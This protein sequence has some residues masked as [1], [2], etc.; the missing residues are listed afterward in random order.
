MYSPSAHAA[1][2][3]DWKAGRI[4]DDT[5]F[6]NNDAM[7]TSDIQNFLSAQVPV[8]D[9]WGQKTY[10]GQTRAAYSAARGYSTPFVCLKDYQENP[11]THETNL[12]TAGS[13]SGGWSAAQIIK[14]AADTY[15]ISPSALIVLLQKEQT[16]VTDD[17]PWPNQ[18]RSA[19]GYGCPDTAPCDA[20][21]YGFY[22]QVMNAAAAFKRYATNPQSYRYKAYQNN[23]ILYNPS[24][25]CGS[26]SVYLENQA[27]AGLYIY[28]PY[29]PNQAALSNL[30]GTGDSCSAYGNR[31][32]WR[33]YIDWFGPTTG[34]FLIQSPASPAV[35]L[36]TG[37]TRYGIPSYDV[38]RAYGF[39]TIRVTPVTD[40]YM[41]SLAD[42]GVLGTTFKK[43]GE[44]AVYL[45]DNGY[46]F[47]FSSYQQCIDWGM[48]NCISAAKG[49]PLSIFN[50]IRSYGDIKSLM[51]NGS[52]IYLM[53]N[54]EKMP[55][56]SYKALTEKGY[57]NDDIIPITSTLN[58]NQPISYSII[59]N[60]SFITFKGSPVIYA[61]NDSHF[62]PLTYE[63]FRSL[64]TDATPIMVD[65]D[66][67]YVTSPPQQDATIGQIVSYSNGTTYL[68]TNNSKIDITATKNNWT[69]SVNV[70][71]IKQIVDRKPTTAAASP[72]S[73]FR[74]VS[75]AIFKVNAN[76][77]QP[78]YS[79]Y[80]YFSL[81]YTTPIAVGDEVPGLLTAGEPVIAPGAGS[82]Y[83]VNT[84]GKE[85]ALY[86][87]SAD[88]T[89]CQISS[90]GQLGEYGFL[91]SN[92]QRL[93][94]PTGTIKPLSNLVT[95]NDG[96]VYLV[97]KG[98]KT[99]IDTDVLAERWGVN[100]PATSCSFTS[101][102]VSK[103]QSSGQTF[104]RFIRDSSG[105]IYYGEN[106]TKRPIYSYAKFL[107]LGGNSLNT[108]DVPSSFLESIPTGQPIL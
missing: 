40:S 49:L 105:V 33:M 10:S 6:F 24:S 53:K 3:A 67:K 12:T 46:R 101:Q 39:D 97:M 102:F 30:Y 60:N 11:T 85:F 4:I 59:E 28:T 96:K 34:T 92:V 93:N 41:S 18:Y 5:V 35:Y 31:N 44:D 89:I 77:L 108:I 42:G 83:Q 82:I 68:L 51:L 50:Q 57:T 61:Y 87:L 94:E 74:S 73:P 81:G 9:T 15:G 2:A 84:P 58:S 99:Y 36:T 65:N 26:S 76:K 48:P 52:A 13:V 8:C 103:I 66:S 37:T 63:A 38:L 88:N 21:Y 62:Y 86:A 79:L 90:M 56:L 91:T 25:S 98:K 95:S 64:S 71:G 45:A 104:G 78:F 22:N 23:D 16:L 54:G 107:S 47:G 106:K 70:D 80:D 72:S 20:Q 17:W 69:Q 100:S 75:G 1:N 32:F 14:Y 29:Q 7:S 43:E 27:T 55:F 19:T